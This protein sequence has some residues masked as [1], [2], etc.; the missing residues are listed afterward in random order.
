V[1]GLRFHE[2]F[3]VSPLSATERKRITRQLLEFSELKF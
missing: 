1:E 3:E 2:M